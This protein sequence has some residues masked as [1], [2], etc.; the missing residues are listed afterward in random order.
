MSMKNSSDTIGN[1]NRDLP[2]SSAASTS[3]TSVMK[4]DCSNKYMY[5]SITLATVTQE[6]VPVCIISN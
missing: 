5:L 3:G 1:G 6:G 2:T 4:A